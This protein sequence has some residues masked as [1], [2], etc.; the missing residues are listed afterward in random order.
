MSN[1]HPAS[2]F[3]LIEV[4]VAI[5][6]LVAISVG[7]AQLIA[8]ATRATRTA[9]EH[10]SAVI[11]A[12][13]KMDQLRSLAWAYEPAV[14]GAPAVPRTDLTTN[15]SHPAHGDDGRG[16]SASPAETLSR[17]MPPYVDYLDDA[18]SWVGNDI[19]PPPDAVFVRRWAV[20]P[21]PDEDDP[22]RTLVL[23]VVVTPIRL[24]RSRSTGWQHR[25]GTE[26]MLVSV[27][28]RKGL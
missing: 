20:V 15:L 27:L 24:D 10:T 12:A 6:I 21:L 4:L 28:T 14:A 9:R 5:A 19:E 11:L 7:V 8:V 22:D 2:G 26:A 23:Q 3:T 13:A 18:G 1:R 25:S 17:N 16:L